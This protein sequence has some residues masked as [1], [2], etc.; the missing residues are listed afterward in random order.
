MILWYDGTI[1][2]SQWIIS[3]E[4][5]GKSEKLN[6]ISKPTT[7]LQKPIISSLFDH[8]PTCQTIEQKVSRYPREFS[9]RGERDPGETHAVE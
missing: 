2:S 5:V 8:G 9:G 6:W 3:D 1:Q 7:L 4:V